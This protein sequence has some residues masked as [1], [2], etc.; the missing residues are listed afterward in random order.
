MRALA[1]APC[2]LYPTRSPSR[3]TPLDPLLHLCFQ[4]DGPE[5]ERRLTEKAGPNG[6]PP[7]ATP[8]TNQLLTLTLTLIPTLTLTLALAANAK[9]NPN[10]NPHQ[11]LRQ[12]PTAIP[13]MEPYTGATRPRV[14]GVPRARSGVA[15]P[16]TPTHTTR[17]TLPTWARGW[18][19]T[20]SAATLTASGRARGA[21][22][23][24]VSP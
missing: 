11:C 19:N 15:R 7:P 13:A 4:A 16:Q 6:A 20:T 3:P 5:A 12:L 23:P 8:T 21:T 10:P 18:A 24:T 17:R 22:L 9:P 14:T 2:T 1:V